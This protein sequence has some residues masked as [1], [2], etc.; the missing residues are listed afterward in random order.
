M[1][2]SRARFTSTYTQAQKDA[3]LRSVLVH[4]RS[5]AATITLA[6]QGKLDVPA[7]DVGRYAYE[8]VKRGR[9]AYELEHEDALKAGGDDELR[10]AENAAVAHMRVIRH[11]LKRD[12]TDNLDHMAKA[13]QNLAQIRKARREANPGQKPPKPATQ[14]AEPVNTP[15]TADVLQRLVGLAPKNG[16]KGARG[17]VRST[18]R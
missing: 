17:A 10:L 13:A 1:S 18:S 16:G 6:G 4:G 12:G 14:G 11:G 7:F 15:E 3:V 2:E 9:D 5:V 8:I